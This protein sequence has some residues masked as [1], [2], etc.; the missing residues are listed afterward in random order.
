MRIPV[1]NL[2]LLQLFASD[3][4]QHHGDE[5]AGAEE[6]PEDLPQLVA[7][8]LAEEVESRLHTGLSVGFTRAEANLH[9]VR[10]RIDVLDTTRHRLL[11]RGLVRCRYDTIVTDTPAN[12]LVRSALRKAAALLPNDPRYRSLALQLEAAGVTGPAPRPDIVPSLRRQR[13]LARDHRM[14]SLAEL[15]LTMSVP[16]PA[17]YEFVTVAPDDSD[18]YLRKL[19]ERAVYGFYRHTLERRGW[20]VRPG[21]R[22][23][24]N[25][26]RISDGMQPVLPGMQTDITLRAPHRPGGNVRR[27]VVIDTKFTA[28][29]Q[30]GHH[31]TTTLNSHYLYQ[32]YAYLMSQHHLGDE[33]RHAEGLM[34]HPV[35]DGHFDED[36]V[37][38]G[39]RIR[40][41]TVDLRASAITIA[42]HLIKAISPSGDTETTT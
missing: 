31:R 4:Y 5:F 17:H 18:H 3:L 14:L 8:M 36:V 7:Q 2:W 32:I 40:F 1:R 30:A 6:L 11:E 12:R 33:H 9:R 20:S 29:T 24:W 37:I 34:L 10:G 38:Q 22:L 27:R 25:I 41:A 15:L 42:H 35:V 21:T 26:D 13:L 16:D 23:S 39:H 19:F 28:I